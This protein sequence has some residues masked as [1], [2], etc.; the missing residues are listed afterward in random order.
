MW[1]SKLGPLLQNKTSLQSKGPTSIAGCGEGLVAPLHL[2]W[3][4]GSKQMLPK[5]F[6]KIWWES[7]A[8]DRYK[9]S[10]IVISVYFCL[11]KFESH[12]V[13]VWMFLRRHFLTLIWGPK[14][15]LKDLNWSNKQSTNPDSNER[16]RVVV[17]KPLRFGQPMVAWRNCWKGW[18]NATWNSAKQMTLKMSPWGK[19]PTSSVWDQ[20]RWGNEMEW[21]ECALKHFFLIGKWVFHCVDINDGTWDLGHL[22]SISQGLL[23]GDGC[24]LLPAWLP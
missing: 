21:G 5:H 2:R 19:G 18:S 6:T 17:T 1:G 7:I 12:W 22:W 9:G 10:L 14:T 3:S 4:F 13:W 20:K 11:V 16:C 15:G 23:V 24:C 8:C